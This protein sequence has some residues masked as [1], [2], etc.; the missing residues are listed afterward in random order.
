M[1]RCVALFADY[2]RQRSR[3][4]PEGEI[5][6]LIVYTTV[7]F[8]RRLLWRF[9]P[10]LDPLDLP[11]DDFEPEARLDFDGLRDESFLG[12]ETFVRPLDFESDELWLE[13]L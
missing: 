10:E 4:H 5:A 1:V 9:L 6:A 3:D 13:L 8:Q 7:N 2:E 11:D 12:V